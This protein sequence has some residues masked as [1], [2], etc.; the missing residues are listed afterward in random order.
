MPTEREDRDHS[1]LDYGAFLENFGAFLLES[2]GAFSKFSR[3]RSRP[4]SAR[5]EPSSCPR[6]TAHVHRMQTKSRPD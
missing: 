2:F 1:P 5:Q 3:R 6:R 4:D